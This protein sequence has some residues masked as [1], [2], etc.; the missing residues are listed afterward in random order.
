[1]RIATASFFVLLGACSQREPV[2]ASRWEGQLGKELTGEGVAYDVKLG[3]ML[4]LPDA[5]L[6]VDGIDAWPAGF[7]G[8]KVRATGVLIVKGDL[9]L[10]VRKPDE[11]VR[12]GIEVPP[13]T[14]LEKASRRYLLSKA[15]YS[16][17]AD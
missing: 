15:K 12:S 6:W 4:E 13:G 8:K 17:L 9:P 16:K 5:V 14:D 3:A 10:F 2:P 1:M 7:N 11:P